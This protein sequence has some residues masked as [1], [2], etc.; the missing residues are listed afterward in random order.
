MIRLLAAAVGMA[1]VL[2]AVVLAL[3]AAVLVLISVV[4]RQAVNVDRQVLGV[5]L[6]LGGLVGWGRVA[7]LLAALC[8]H[9]QNEG[10]QERTQEGLIAALGGSCLAFIGLDYWIGS[11]V[12]APALTAVVLLGFF[13]LISPGILFLWRYWRPRR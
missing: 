6:I 4:D 8:R 5:F 10:L 11:P 12:K 9:P 3:L 13:L 1:V 2:V 7:V